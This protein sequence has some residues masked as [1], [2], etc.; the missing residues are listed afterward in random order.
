MYV[1]TITL[2]QFR[3]YR[4]A[5]ISFSPLTNIIYGNNAQGKTNILEAVYLFSQGRSYRTK[6]DRELVMFGEQ[7]SRITSVFEDTRRDYRAELRVLKDGRKAIKINEVPIT[8]LS[9]LMS[10]FNTVMFSPEDLELIKGAPGIRRK[11]LDA[12]ISQM[13]P[14]Y[15]NALIQ[16]N[17]TL[18]QK[19][20]LL[21]T[22]RMSSVRT[23]ETLSVWNEQLAGHAAVIMS[24]RTRFLRELAQ[25]AERIYSDI[26]K[27]KLELRYAP[28]M[29]DDGAEDGCQD[30]QRLWESF[31]RYQRREIENGSSMIGVQRDDIA[32]SI[33]GKDAKMY[34]SQGQQ[35]SSVL[36]IKIAQT[37]Y[38]HEQ[39]GEYPVL[40]L[41][42]VMSELDMHRRSYL[43][44]R[45]QNKQTLITCTDTDVVKSTENTK[46]F[47]VEN[48]TVKE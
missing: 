46:L 25:W 30:K 29:R 4:D 37:E 17:K 38:I 18:A 32:V 13:Y 3:N 28:N 31:E 34:G 10:Y 8:K 44:E 6:S 35:R 27:E 45:I 2:T 42:D 22:L 12:A 40:L 39:K 9:M 14:N 23:D 7:F 43:A 1:K 47:Y 24:H 36:S 11:F 33:D 19:N 41:D 21:K 20:S 5:Q 16:Y 15:L 26:G 48:G